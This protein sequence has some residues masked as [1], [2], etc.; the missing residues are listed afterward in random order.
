MILFLII[1]GICALLVVL[2]FGY[3][4]KTVTKEY[5]TNKD[6]K[7][8]GNKKESLMTLLDRIEWANHHQGRHPKLGRLAFFAVIISF[9]TSIIYLGEMCPLNMMQ[10]I[11]V[12]WVI[13]V[14]G[15]TFFTFHSD[16]FSSYYIDENLKH[17]RRKLRLK[18]RV[19]NLKIN[20][21]QE[22]DNYNST[23]LHYYYKHFS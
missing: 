16:K 18:S 4:I 6:L 22:D 2:I 5:G 11:I 7:A 9:F 23:C 12:I 8:H 13:L 14:T 10:S 21:H 17:V 20:P 19:D 3:G 15:N 1:Y